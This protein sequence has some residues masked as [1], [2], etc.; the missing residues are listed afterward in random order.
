MMNL[1]KYMGRVLLI[2]GLV[3][4]S[5]LTGRAEAQ[6]DGNVNLSPAE[7][8]EGVLAKYLGQDE[9]RTYGDA[10]RARHE[11]AVGSKGMVAGTT[12]AAAVHAGIEALQQ[13]GSAVDA[14]MTTA[15]TQICFAGGAW[16]SYGGF[17]QMM[18]YD[19]AT[20][21]VHN[22]NAAFNTVLGE[23]DPMSIPGGVDLAGTALLPDGRTALVPGFL[24]GVEAAHK[25]FG[26]LPFEALFQPAIYF[27]E[28][29]F[30]VGKLLGGM[31]KSKEDVLSRLPET[32]AVYTKE[33]GEFYSEG[34]IF[35]QPKVAETLRRAAR[36]G[37]HAYIYEG[38]WAEHFVAA[39]Q[40][41]G[42]KI[43]M[44]DM[45][46][47][48][49]EWHTPISTTYNGYDVYT[50]DL[51]SYGGPGILEALN[52][53]EE[54]GINAKGHYTKSADALYWLMQISNTF[55]TGF[56]APEMR[57]ALIPGVDLSP[58]SRYK[59]ETARTLWKM[60][61]EKD[62][63]FSKLPTDASPKHSDGV[64]AVDQWGNVVALTHTINTSA[65]GNTG[66]NVD[67]ISIPDAAKF[68]QQQIQLAG[69]GKKLGD[70][71]EP[72]LVM[73]DGKPV[74]AMSSIGS[75]LH[76]KTLCSLINIL[77]FGMNPKEAVDTSSLMLPD[78]AQIMA[79][80]ATAQ[81]AEG[82]F[83][84]D[85]VKALEARGQEVKLLTTA[86]V[87]LARGYVVAI[88]IDPESGRLEGG[89]PGEFLGGAEGY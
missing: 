45:R 15:L 26:K 31:I 17:M 41:D 6:S 23:D 25:R 74:V 53:V 2:A 47:Y 18:Y 63:L 87:G 58:A 3:S 8:G 10:M 50:L 5:A 71:T 67:G 16:V 46:A 70:P 80:T 66:I 44:D 48:R 38:E 62:T 69:P 61:Q 20:G 7:W 89:C 73:K 77:D 54:S 12:G 86:E 29:G 52:L 75:G 51:P 28:E 60:M 55:V 84:A 35:R 14:A 30:P 27:A 68:Q 39:V 36:E 34:D 32:K 65:W 21:E 78:L 64:V 72:L 56:V 42:G 85:L 59:K 13:G 1:R 81:L 57:A 43:T 33:D 4:V 11:L 40:R 19:A 49:A 76:Q 37:V 22:L 9:S 24:G 79:G 83:D 88:T 82:E